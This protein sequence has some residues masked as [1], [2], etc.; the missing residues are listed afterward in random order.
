MPGSREY[1]QAF[2]NFAMNTMLP[3]TDLKDKEQ[4]SIESDKFSRQYKSEHFYDLQN[5]ANQENKPVIRFYGEEAHGKGE[6]D[7]VGGTHDEITRDVI[8]SNAAQVAS[9]LVRKFEAKE[10]PSYINILPPFILWFSN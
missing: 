6:V 10:N 1:N 9:Y 2:V 5:I 4:I 7:H 8:F 3:A